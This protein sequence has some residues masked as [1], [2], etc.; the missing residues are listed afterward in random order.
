MFL[1][2]LD[3]MVGHEMNR[4]VRS[5]RYSK[6]IF[7]TSPFCLTVRKFWQLILYSVL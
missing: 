6:D 5:C 2:L 1:H 7:L 3:G 4:G